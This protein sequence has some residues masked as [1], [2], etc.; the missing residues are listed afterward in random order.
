MEYFKIANLENFEISKSGVIRNCSN[1]KI[2][3]QY[4]SSTGYY[5]ISVSINNKSK[6]YRVHR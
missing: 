4:I 2:K 5:M 6:P 3:S 1:L